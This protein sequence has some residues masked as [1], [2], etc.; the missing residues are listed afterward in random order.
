M[1][2]AVKQ[3]EPVGADELRA[4]VLRR[5]AEATEG[6]VEPEAIAAGASLRDDLGLGSLD[7]L[8]LVLDLEERY[9]IDVEDEE[10]AALDTVE[11]LLAL[12]EAK[13]SLGAAT[14]PA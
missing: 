1:T 2:P 10:L 6:K 9:G 7:A 13:R 11:G 12:V 5:I 8:L 14:A 3:I 4:E